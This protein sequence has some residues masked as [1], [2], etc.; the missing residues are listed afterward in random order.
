[1]FFDAF[2]GP[3]TNQGTALSVLRVIFED[4]VGLNIRVGYRRSK[5]T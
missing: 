4:K 2:K 1:M 3:V 5:I